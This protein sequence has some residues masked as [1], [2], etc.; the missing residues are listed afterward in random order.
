LE[1]LGPG[2][3]A[4]KTDKTALQF[5]IENHQY[6]VLQSL[7][8][9]GADLGNDL[10][11]LAYIGQ[12]SRLFFGDCI[13]ENLKRIELSAQTTHVFLELRF[14]E[15][16]LNTIKTGNSDKKAPPKAVISIF[17]DI[18]CGPCRKLHGEV[19]KLTKLG[20][21]VRYL[22]FPRQGLESSSCN[23]MISVWCAKNPK[24]ALDHAMRG[25]SIE[26]KTCNN[27]VQQHYALGHKWGI[28]GTPTIV[29]ED[30]TT[31]DGFIPADRLAKMAIAHKKS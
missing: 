7:L 9:H 8:F 19:P 1:I 21:E 29:F 2:V 26:S 4:R 17:S 12:N 28:M 16:T 24:S 6:S 5:A 23:K 20:I 3:N 18:D 25:E 27:P 11:Y 13:K 30:G 31:E 14:L 15:K 10:S 22:A